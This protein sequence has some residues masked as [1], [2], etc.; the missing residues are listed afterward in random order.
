MLL[1]SCSKNDGRIDALENRVNQIESFQIA[2]IQQQIGAIN[3]SL[4]ELKQLS[5]DLKKYIE[6]LQKATLAIEQTIKDTDADVTIVETKLAQLE[7]IITALQQKDVALEQRIDALEEYVDTKLQSNK[8]WVS[9]TFATLEQYNA[10]AD[11]V[12]LVKQGVESVTASIAALEQRLGEKIAADIERAITTYI[13]ALELYMK[14]WVNE[15]LT[16]YYTIAEVDATLALLESSLT[17][18]DTE[19]RGEIAVLEKRLNSLEDSMTAAYQSAITDAIAQNNGVINTKIATEVATINGRIDAEIATI[20]S[21]IDALEDRIAA[22]EN[23]IDQIQSLDIIFDNADNLAC[24]PGMS[25]VVN[26]TIVGGDDKTEIEC[27]GDGGWSAS[28]IKDSATTG[29]VKVFAPKDAKNGKVVVLATSGV[30]GVVMK[31][32]YFD[33]GI[34]TDIIDTYQVG[35]EAC[36]VLVK[37]KTNLNYTVNIPDAAQS[38]ISVADTRAEIREDVLAFSIMENDPYNSRSVIVKLVD[39]GGDVL[40]TL[41]FVQKAQPAVFEIDGNNRC[42]VDSNGGTVNVPITTN[43]EYR[44]EIPEEAHIWLSV[45]DTRAM[46]REETLTFVASENTNS[47][48]RSAI[49]KL[50]GQDDAILQTIEIYQN[51]G[52]HCVYKE[53]WYTNGSTT[54]ATTPWMTNAFDANIVS[55]TYNTE[56]MCWI[57]KFDGNVTTIWNSAFYECDSLTSITIPD[58]VTTIENYAFWRCSSL[59]S[60]IIPNSI[61]TIGE[62]A[63]LD[64]SSLTSVTIGDSVTTIGG[65]AFAN[66][67]NLTSVTIPDSVTTIG[68]RAFSGC[69]SLTSVTISDSVTTIG[70]GAFR[71]CSSLREFNGKYASDNGRCLIIDNTLNSFAPAGLTEYTI[72]DSVTT[73]G[74]DAFYGCSSLTSVIIGDSVTEIG[75]SAFEDCSS[76]T[77]ITIPDS[78]TEIG[79]Y[80]FKGCSSL[81]SVT[82]GDSVTTIGWGAFSDCSSLT[83]VYCKA[84]TPPAGGSYMFSYYENGYKPIGCTI[85]VPMESVEAYK[86]AS[87]WSSYADDIVG[88]NFENGVVVPNTPPNNEIWYT[89]T[90]GNAV[91]PILTHTIGSAVIESFKENIISNNYQDGKGVIVFEDDVTEVGYAAFNGCSKLLTI[92]LSTTV[93]TIGNYTFYNCTNL[94]HITLPDNITYI[95]GYA[96]CGCSNLCEVYCESAIPPTGNND[97]FDGNASGR[98]IY[99]PMESVEAYKSA[100]YWSDY[101]SSI[102][103]YNF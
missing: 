28:I 9:A 16:G 63:F 86:A 26:Y 32:L 45:A 27:F 81:T 70:E 49:V 25:T 13:K 40:Q 17:D 66:C 8:D 7:S 5:A 93:E 6:D 42:I 56:M 34:L 38:W 82:I 12:A 95:G 101:A 22:L 80:A 58:S 91:E 68:Y 98:K 90:D 65:H 31:S 79:D 30:G 55:N 39:V 94:S 96:F 74:E 24:M 71:R 85:Y 48:A 84:I 67:S 2:S 18:A 33:K 21:R 43:L 72:P 60:V 52:V 87:Y 103:G 47:E 89:S 99:V 88:Y 77:S 41:S 62:A 75:E 36:T 3:A 61:T 64:C 37:L 1:S 83:S 11:E 76:L 54:T 97:M 44:I 73:I 51:R 100:S 59:T 69:S 46:I 20:N 15:M 10:I 14:E 53:I 78:V 50:I 19:L 4:P 35:Y 23:I 92:N 57:I 29:R 102:E